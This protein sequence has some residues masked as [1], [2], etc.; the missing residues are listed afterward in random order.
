MKYF[1]IKIDPYETKI[2]NENACKSVSVISGERF[3]W[4]IPYRKIDES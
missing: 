4:G 2:K 1:K 3:V